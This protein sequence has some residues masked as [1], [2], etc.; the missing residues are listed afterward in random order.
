MQTI[1]ALFFWGS[2]HKNFYGNK[3]LV[4]GKLFLGFHFW[5]FIFV[6]FL[7]SEILSQNYFEE[8]IL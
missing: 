2:D 4:F 6:H 3:F 5:T 1:F 7:K 8:L